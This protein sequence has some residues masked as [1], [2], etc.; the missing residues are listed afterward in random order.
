MSEDS[1]EYPGQ[2]WDPAR[3]ETTWPGVL[4]FDSLNGALLSLIVGGEKPSLFPESK[5]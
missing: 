3:P 1:F 5:S 4:R 2:W